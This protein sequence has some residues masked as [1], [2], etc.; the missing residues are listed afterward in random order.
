MISSTRT[1]PMVLCLL[2]ASCMSVEESGYDAKGS[3]VSQQNGFTNSPSQKNLMT[4]LDG[5]RDNKWVIHVKY[6]P[7]RSFSPEDKAKIEAT[8][9]EDINI[10]LQSLRD[11]NIDVVKTIEVTSGRV[12][13]PDLTI[14]FNPRS[15]QPK[16]STTTFEKAALRGTRITINMETQTNL[17]DDSLIPGT[18]D[19]SRNTLRH[20]LGHALGLNDTYDVRTRKATGLHPPSLMSSFYNQFNDSS[21]LAH[22]TKDDIDSLLIYYK[23][24]HEGLYPSDACVQI[25]ELK[26][27][28]GPPAG[29]VPSK[30]LIYAIQYYDDMDDFVIGDLLEDS[31]VKVNDIDKNKNSALHLALTDNKLNMAE[32]IL[33]SGGDSVDP[34]LKNIAGNTVL[35]LATANGQSNQIAAILDKLIANPN[36]NLALTNDKGET[37]YDLALDYNNRINTLKISGEPTF[38]ASNPVFDDNMLQR[39]NP[40]P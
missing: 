36:T 4:K 7:S 31:R 14:E 28:L 3:N 23:I 25:S 27:D 29:C 26:Y 21:R 35:H 19:Y 9:E 40:N 33:S 6:H 34:S 2:I 17:S 20:E 5:G 37:A 22:L 11:K 30:P 15:R 12:F 8:I 39:L 13:T 32:A 18:S 1:T 38:A 10:W 24:I 16:E